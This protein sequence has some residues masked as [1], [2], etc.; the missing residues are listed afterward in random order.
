MAEIEIGLRAVVGD[1]HLAMLER[2]HRA[3]IDVQIGIELPQPH[4][5]AA[6]LQERAREPPRRD[7]FPRE[8]TTPPVMKINRAMEWH[9]GG[10]VRSQLKWKKRAASESLRGPN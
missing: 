7:P 4:A 5:I 3:G 9:H 6:R 2:T 1:I 10:S 8:E